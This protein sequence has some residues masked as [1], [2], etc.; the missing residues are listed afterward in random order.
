MV[1]LIINVMVLAFF[2]VVSAKFMLASRHAGS[3]R[4]GQISR[5]HF[6]LL[7]LGLGLLL[8]K[9]VR[10]GDKVLIVGQAA[11]VLAAFAYCLQTYFMPTATSK[12]KPSPLSK[13]KPYARRR[14]LA[15]AGGMSVLVAAVVAVW[16]VRSFNTSS[17]GTL[18]TSQ[19]QPNSPAPQL[20]HFNGQRFRFSYSDYF[21]QSH[22]DPPRQPILENYIFVRH[23]VLAWQLAI[24]IESL[25]S[26]NVND[27]G[28]Y[29]FR[30]VT[31]DRFTDDLVSVNGAMVHVFS[32]KSSGFNFSKVLYLQ[33]QGLVAS[34]ALSGGTPD[35]S[36]AM[37]TALLGIASS[38]QW[39]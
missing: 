23:Q 36:A 18:D 13:T 12:P 39:R 15:I 1:T 10:L 28:S 19:V 27:D 3:G 21:S 35:D 29:H 34:L 8:I 22:T 26:G 33:H 7:L 32:D 2:G 11:L 4:P 25:P 31:P 16:L 5:R 17:Q 9:F 38:W 20:V 24:Q 6:I 14:T 30:S 37:Q